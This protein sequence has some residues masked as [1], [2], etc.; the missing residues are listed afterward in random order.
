AAV[1][2]LL[3]G[4]LCISRSVQK[5]ALLPLPFGEQ[6]SLLQQEPLLPRG[7]FFSSLAG[8][9]FLSSIIRLGRLIFFS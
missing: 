2:R 5:K 9:A 6:R 8:S 1:N 3:Y 7:A 4:S